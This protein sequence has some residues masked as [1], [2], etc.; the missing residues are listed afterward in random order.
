MKSTFFRDLWEPIEVWSKALF[1]EL[2]PTYGDPV[3]PELR[4]FEAQAEEAQQHPREE[5]GV[6]FPHH[7]ASKP[8]KVGSGSKPQAA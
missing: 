4:V 3:P 5:G 6:S 7:Q 1:T 2:P 8:R